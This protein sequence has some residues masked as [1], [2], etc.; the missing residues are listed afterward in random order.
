MDM[1]QVRLDDLINLVTSLHPDG[2][3]LEH[4]S[5]AVA[6]SDRLGDLADHLIGHFV[7]QARKTGA[8]WTVIGTSMGVSKQAAQKRFVPKSADTKGILGAAPFSRFTDRAR[9]V[10]TA[11]Q[12]EARTAGHDYIGTEH[13]VLGLLA[14]PQALGART[15]ADQSITAEQLRAAMKVVL[16]PQQDSVPEHIVFTPRAKKVLELAAR[17]ALRLDHNF[18]GTEHLLLGV[19]AEE[20]GVGAKVLVALGFDKDKAE[21]W[22]LNQLTEIM[23]RREAELVAAT[24][25]I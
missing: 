10:I 20:E 14:D 8:S 4:L 11:A 23:K 13:L 5:D 21:R 24:G 16:G 3:A 19:L 1:P 6:V 12:Q 15:L 18:V 25:Q 2:D 17:E 7:D 9:T 22:I